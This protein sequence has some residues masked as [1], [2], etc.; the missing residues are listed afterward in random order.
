M[1]D[2]LR[3]STFGRVVHSLSGNRLFRYEEQLDPSLVAHYG[4]PESKSPTSTPS[5]PDSRS[6][7]QE[8]G[9]DFQLVEFTEG[10]SGNPRNWSTAKKCF[11]TFQICFLTTSVYIG[12]VL[13]EGG[14]SF[15]H[16]AQHTS[17]PNPIA[18]LCIVLTIERSAIYTAGLEG[19]MQ[20]FGVSQVVALLGLTLFVLGYATG[21]MILVSS[22]HT[23][24]QDLV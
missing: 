10:D 6:I 14:S 13:S 9:R 21:P 7:D 4:L 19:V 5:T 3:E 16:N 1:A 18:V 22:S 23:L 24:C 12:Y 8:K 11:V 20:Q 15:K 2:I 17:F